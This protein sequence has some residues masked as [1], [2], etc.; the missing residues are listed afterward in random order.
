MLG[1]IAWNERKDIQDSFEAESKLA[2]RYLTGFFFLVIHRN[3]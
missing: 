1:C 3:W 2:Y